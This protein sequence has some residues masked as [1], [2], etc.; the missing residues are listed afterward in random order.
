LSRRHPGRPSIAPVIALA[1]LALIPAV[2]FAYGWRWAAGRV[3]KEISDPP[4]ADAA[5]PPALALATPILSIR[6]A[7]QTLA[8]VK[9]EEGLVAQL[10]DVAVN[11]INEQSCL[12]VTLDGRTVFDHGGDTPVTPASNEK[13][14]TAAVALKALGPDYAFTTALKGNLVDGVVDGDLYFVGGGDPLLSTNDYVTSNLKY[15]PFNVTSLEALADNLVA[16]GVTRV[17]GKVVGDESR[18]DAERYVP[19]WASDI[20]D[21]EAGPLSAL[22]VNDSTRQIG[23]VRR[24]TDNQGGPA[25]GAARTLA[26]LL[27]DRGVAVGGGSAAGSAPPDAPVLASVQSQPMSAIVQE[28]LTTSDDNTAEML[29]KEVGLAVGGAGTTV[30]GAQAASTTLQ[31]MGIDIGKLNIVDGSGLDSSNIVRC[32]ILIQI[33]AMQPLDGPIAT[34]LPVAAQTGSLATEFV[35]SPIAGQLHAKTGSLSNVKSLT[36]YLPTA[37]GTIELSMILNGQNVGNEGN[38]LPAWNAL[39]SA[40]ATYPSGPPVDQVQPR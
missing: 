8:T 40:L 30:A 28:M 38:Y 9:S 15:P 4:V 2:L 11:T 16:A 12:V 37:A 32:N 14:L 3:P 29:L 5:A 7:P 17:R 34:G 1:F 35:D 33:L 31:G 39:G 23:T 24:W 25:A 20:K 6:R 10:N 26:A 21:Q 36:G 22:M 13:L 18:Y 27:Q 19:T